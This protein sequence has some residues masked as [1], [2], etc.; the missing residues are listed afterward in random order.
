MELSLSERLRIRLGRTGSLSIIG[1]KSPRKNDDNN[2]NNNNT[3]INHEKRNNSMNR[4][5]HVKK[6]SKVMNLLNKFTNAPGTQNSVN[7]EVQCKNLSCLI[8]LQVPERPCVSSCGHVCCQQCWYQHL[9]VMK[10]CPCCRQEVDESKISK[11]V[12]R[13]DSKSVLNS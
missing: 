4:V 2:N 8:C 13:D 5:A 9:K 12:L 10:T 7:N 1:P 11:L 6:K 3:N